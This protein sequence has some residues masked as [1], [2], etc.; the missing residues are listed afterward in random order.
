MARPPKFDS[1]QKQ[2]IVLAVLRGELSVA[3]AAHRAPMRM[4]G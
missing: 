4:R 1:K 2:Q 3:E